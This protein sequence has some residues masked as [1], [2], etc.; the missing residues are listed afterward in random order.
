[1]Y[2]HNNS[3][4]LPLAGME[5]WMKQ[6][7][8][9][10][11]SYIVLTIT[12]CGKQTNLVRRIAVVVVEHSAVLFCQRLGVFFQT[13]SLTRSVVPLWF[14]LSVAKHK[15]NEPHAAFLLECGSFK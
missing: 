15:Q 9:E 1:M 5:I 7:S 13:S 4:L 12:I 10:K 2:E 3:P 14:Q 6:E 8:V 11:R